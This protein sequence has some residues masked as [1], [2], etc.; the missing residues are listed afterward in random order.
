[1]NFNEFHPFFKC[2]FLNPKCANTLIAY[3]T[4]IYTTF[5]NFYHLSLVLINFHQ[6]LPTLCYFYKFYQ[7]PPICITFYQFLSTFML[8][9]PTFPTF[10]QLLPLLTNFYTTFATFHYLPPF[11]TN[12]YITFT[13][14]NFYFPQAFTSILP[15]LT[16]ILPT[17]HQFLCY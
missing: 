2:H 6:F 14:L 3:T 7:L 9:L 4:N 10:H 1:M 11:F 12:F 17:S 5:T 16:N 8:L 15:L 13:L